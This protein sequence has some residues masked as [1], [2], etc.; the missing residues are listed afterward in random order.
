MKI[1]KYAYVGV[2]AILASC[3]EDSGYTI[4]GTVKNAQ[5][6]QR[7]F[8][9]ELS[10]NS[11]QTTTIDTL[12]VRNGGFEA[13][14]PEKDKPT[15]SFLTLEGARGNVLYVA[16]NTTI[17]FEIY[18]D[19][20][21]ASKVT[22]GKGNELLYNYFD[23]VRSYNEVATASRNE[24][25][26]AFQRQDTA[27]LSRLQQD[28]QERAEQDMQRKKEMVEEHPNS[29]VSVLI[30]Q[31]MVNSGMTTSKEAKE[32][33]NNLSS[34]VQN[35][36]LGQMLNETIS[37]MSQVE[38]GSKAPEF[39]A[40]T[41]D[42]GELALNDVL[43]KVTL[44]DFWA[45]WCKPCRDENP[46]IARVYRKYH[47]QGLNILGVSLDRPG[48]KERWVQA[49]AED[50]LAWNHVSHLMYWDDPVARKYGIRG[51]PAAFLL[52]ENGVIVAKDLRGKALEDKVA[53]LLSAN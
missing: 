46:N 1:I 28:Q 4:Q 5:D 11:N 41:P 29:I 25:M 21:Y 27:R 19:S 51:I 33:Y 15:L 45:S 31:D 50:S 22:G 16:D 13:D 36:Q 7:I 23:D 35:T 14:L 34:D 42:G 39:T 40:P 32:Y 17:E 52:D 3:Q 9:S 49:I 6:G 18:P 47:D 20:L 12:E 10:E 53:E 48:Q 30:L 2:L 8:V 38:I 37:R 26:Q 24:M 44:V 43:G